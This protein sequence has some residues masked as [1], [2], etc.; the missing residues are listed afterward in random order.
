MVNEQG[1][2]INWNNIIYRKKQTNRRKKQS[3][4][5]LHKHANITTVP[6]K[7]RTNSKNTFVYEKHILLRSP[8]IF[9]LLDYYSRRQPILS[10]CSISITPENVRKP[11]VFWRFQ[12]V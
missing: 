12:G 10:Q 11:L 9:Y 7:N 6:K 1:K 3:I 2:N 5:K 4:K 8:Y